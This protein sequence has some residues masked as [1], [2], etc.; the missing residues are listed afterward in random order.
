MTTDENLELV[1]STSDFEDLP[2]IPRHL[3]DSVALVIVQK[4]QP[5]IP[6]TALSALFEILKSVGTTTDSGTGEILYRATDAA[7]NVIPPEMLQAFK[8][9][10]G[11]LGSIKTPSSFSQARLHPVEVAEGSGA[12][13]AV[14]SVDPMLAFIAVALMDINTKLDNIN[15]MQQ[16]MFAYAKLR[17][18]SKLVAA[19]NV[20]AELRDN[21]RFNSDNPAYLANRHQRVS[22]ALR[23]AENAIE[24]QRGRLLGT[25]DPLGKLRLGKDV[26]KKRTEMAEALKDYRLASYLYGYAT[27][28]DILLV[29]NYEPAYLKSVSDKM[30]KYSLEYFSLYNKCLD[31]IEADARG[32]V[33]ALL[34]GG[35]GFASEKLSQLIAQTPIG[36]KTLID[37]ALAS[38]SEKLDALAQSGANKSIEELALAKPG[39]LRPFI[40]TIHELDRLHNEP[41]VL[42]DDDDAIYILPFE[43][44][45]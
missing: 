38:G 11:L 10:S 31:S 43:L 25:L 23:D 20:L 34:A 18:H 9:G 39:F 6:D 45:A 30:E 37:E 3:L 27:I 19:F 2:A 7:G 17:D 4:G 12:G 32:T 40:D 16:N 41:V 35:A 14:A 13:A 24:L 29:G 5:A 44:I 26:Q 22:D 28:M 15:E 42:V 1:P 8:D 36:D 21:Y 33:G